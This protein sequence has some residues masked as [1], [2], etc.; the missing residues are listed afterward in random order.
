MG[1]GGRG[2]GLGQ[3][4]VRRHRNRA[5]RTLW[6][7]Q[8]IP[9]RDK[10]GFLGKVLW[11]NHSSK[12]GPRQGVEQGSSRG[13]ARSSQVEPGS[14]RGRARSS[15]VE[16]RSSHVEP[17]VEPGR[18]RVEPGR[19]RVGE[20]SPWVPSIPDLAFSENTQNPPKTSFQS[21][22]S[23]KNGPGRKDFSG[24]SVL[25]GPFFLRAP[26]RPQAQAGVG[27]RCCEVNLCRRRLMHAASPCSFRHVLIMIPYAVHALCVVGC[28]E[29]LGCAVQ[30]VT[31]GCRRFNCVLVCQCQDTTV[32]WHAM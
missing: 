11:F 10:F 22:R 1:G 23:S 27:E 4:G 26:F 13:R 29:L 16:Q 8:H 25:P 18:A 20:E 12:N 31:G 28:K 17:E 6:V 2:R 3:G 14:S 5:V 32:T 30:S 9:N 24:A 7:G 15:Q 21:P 19:A